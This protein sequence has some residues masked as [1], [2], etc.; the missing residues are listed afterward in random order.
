MLGVVMLNV[1]MLNVVMLNVIMLNVIML[2]V[3]M[4]IVVMLNVISSVSLCRVSWRPYTYLGSQSF[5]TLSLSPK[6]KQCFLK[7]LASISS[8]V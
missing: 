6:N 8:Q 4:L 5:L 1:I 7:S 2:N 3:V